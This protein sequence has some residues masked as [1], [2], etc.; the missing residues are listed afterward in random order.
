MKKTILSALM[1]LIF[2][3]LAGGEEAYHSE[4]I[5]ELVYI[6]AGSF[7]RDEN[8]DNISIVNA[9]RIGKYHISRDQFTQ[10]TGFKDNSF[11]KSIPDAP[12]ENLNWYTAVAFCNNLSM[13]EGLEPVYSIKENRKISDTRFPF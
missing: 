3:G 8:P 10:V 5:G 7:Q 1:V 6:P 2:A 4:Y 11:H 12:V 13:L 9:F